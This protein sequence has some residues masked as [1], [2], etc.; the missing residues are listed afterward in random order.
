MV[1]YRRVDEAQAVALA[2]SEG[3]VRILAGAGDGM[4][5]GAVEEDVVAGG[6]AVELGELDKIVGG[7]V[8]VVADGEDAK[9]NIIGQGSRPV[10]LDRTPDAVAVLGG[11]VK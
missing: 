4:N 6:R 3:H 1:L 10:D 7:V 11:E 9:V 8:V 5:V 2:G